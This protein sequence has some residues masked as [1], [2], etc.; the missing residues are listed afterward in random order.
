MFFYILF[1]RPE[2]EKLKN[3][4]IN[5]H[6]PEDQHVSIDAIYRVFHHGERQR[7]DTHRFA[8]TEDPED[9]MSLVNFKFSFL[10]SNP[11]QI[12]IFLL[13][14]IFSKEFRPFLLK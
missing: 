9:F 12:P 6:L 2:Y 1:K 11:N 13:I 5:E 10:S 4:S 7:G 14:I 3:S 8:L